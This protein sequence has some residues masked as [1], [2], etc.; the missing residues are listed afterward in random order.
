MVKT[1]FM[2]KYCTY[3][4]IV[5]TLLINKNAASQINCPGDLT[6]HGNFLDC[7][8]N[9]DP[10]DPAFTN[11]SP[12][13]SSIT[14]SFSDAT[15][16]GTISYDPFATSYYLLHLPFGEHIVTATAHFCD[17]PTESCI[18][19]VTVT[20]APVPTITCPEDFT[21]FVNPLTCNTLVSFSG[22]NTA[23]SPDATQIIYSYGG[24]S[25]TTSLFLPY[26][27]NI[28]TAKATIPCVGDKTCTF[29]ITVAPNPQDIVFNCPG[30]VTVGCSKDVPASNTSAVTISYNCATLTVEYVDDVIS[31]QTCANRYTITRTYR[32]KEV[33]SVTC[34]QT[35]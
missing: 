21:V 24:V 5:F 20:G 23:L 3:L 26:G 16:T 25:S 1:C 2:R 32:V 33:P 13:A 29:K 12:A 17:Q 4:V 8:A 9:L 30:P 14:Y 22:G 34:S 7:G 31:N 15:G 19:K 28:V 35:I 10:T 11:I 27:E 6:F 18:F